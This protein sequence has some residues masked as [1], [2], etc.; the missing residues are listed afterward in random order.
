MHLSNSL[1]EEKLLVA[2]HVIRGKNALHQVLVDCNRHWWAGC[3]CQIFPFIWDSRS[4][5][6]GSYQGVPATRKSIS[7]RGSRV[8]QQ[9]IVCLVIQESTIRILTCH[10]HSWT[11]NVV[12]Q[13]AES[14][15]EMER[16]PVPAGC[17]ALLWK[18][19]VIQP[20]YS[21]SWCVALFNNK[22][23]WACLSSFRAR[24]KSA[25]NV[26]IFPA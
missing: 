13:W 20:L 22:H 4:A 15:V 11:T 8:A 14:V 26:M 5:R 18:T 6:G 24:L 10:G 3:E 9:K 12:Q 17:P 19:T 21:L 16:H 23:G 7:W 25:T 2:Y 1:E